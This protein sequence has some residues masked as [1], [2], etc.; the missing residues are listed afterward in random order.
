[1]LRRSI[2]SM[3]LLV[4]MSGG[5]IKAMS[6]AKIAAS[7]AGAG[8]A[9][10]S[11]AL[12][13]YDVKP[14]YAVVA[15]SATTFAMNLALIRYSFNSRI[16]QLNRFAE[17]INTTSRSP[18][19]KAHSSEML[20]VA[21]KGY[22]YSKFPVGDAYSALKNIDNQMTGIYNSL[23]EHDS[24]FKIVER[25]QER[26]LSVVNWIDRLSDDSRRLSF[27]AYMKQ[28]VLD[29]LISKM[30]IDW[31]WHLKNAKKN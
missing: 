31:Y 10:G 19:I 14:S 4:V 6:I 22:P 29:G 24:F 8:V 15:A 2:L 5:Q 25:N 12:Y 28:E 26:G 16:K 17:M 13:A 11:S 30:W 20:E 3:I 7:S 21:K 27:N 18:L 23:R 1:M 9:V